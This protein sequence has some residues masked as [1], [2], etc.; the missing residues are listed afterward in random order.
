LIYPAFG[1]KPI[2]E[3]KRSHITKLLDQTVVGNVNQPAALGAPQATDQI[4]VESAAL[5]VAE[6]A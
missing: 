5:Q 1:S 6:R 3:I 4:A 2:D